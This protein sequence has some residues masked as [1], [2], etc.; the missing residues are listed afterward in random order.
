M[1]IVCVIIMSVQ[2]VRL[3]IEARQSETDAG[4]PVGRPLAVGCL[5]EDVRSPSSSARNE[6]S[7]QGARGERERGFGTPV[8]Q[9]ARPVRAMQVGMKAAGFARASTSTVHT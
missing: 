2:G 6:L 7:N 5:E 4:Q 1:T 3:R 9:G 8:D